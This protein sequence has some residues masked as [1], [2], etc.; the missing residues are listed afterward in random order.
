MITA[1]TARGGFTDSAY[2]SRV[3]LIRGSLDHPQLFAVD[4]AAIVNGKSTDFKL[5]PKGHYFCQPSAVCPG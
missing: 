2:R 1:I 5:Q 3:L 4:T